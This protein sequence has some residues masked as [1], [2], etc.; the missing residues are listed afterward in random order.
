MTKNL[1]CLLEKDENS[2]QIYVFFQK[3][4]YYLKFHRKFGYNI[5]TFSIWIEDCAQK[6]I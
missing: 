4:K 5:S 6:Q 2:N 3:V 1:F